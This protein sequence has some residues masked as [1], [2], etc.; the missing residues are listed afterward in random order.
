[1][2][3]TPVKDFMSTKGYDL[4]SPIRSNVNGYLFVTFLDSK[5]PD[6]AENIYLSVKSAERAKVGENIDRKWSI[7][8]YVTDAGV[9]RIKLTNSGDDARA[10]L[11][12]RG[13][14][15]L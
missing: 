4:V 11:I 3:K 1:M 10:T 8:D 13:Y 15:A 9:Q 12:N 7:V 14:V 2:K 6:D 5:N